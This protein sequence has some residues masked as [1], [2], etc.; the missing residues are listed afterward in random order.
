MLAEM[1]TRRD[2]R[3]S[4]EMHLKRF[5]SLYQ[6]VCYNTIH[7][8]FYSGLNYG[9]LFDY[10]IDIHSLDRINLGFQYLTVRA[11]E[12]AAAVMHTID[13]CR[14]EVKDARRFIFM[15]ICHMYSVSMP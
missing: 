15:A 12:H 9:V 2:P 8:L 7:V 4:L 13:K 1:I 10:Q 11:H 6:I 3:P 5:N 14:F